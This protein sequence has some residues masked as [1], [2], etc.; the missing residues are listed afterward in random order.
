MTDKE[1]FASYIKSFNTLFSNCEDLV[2]IKD[3]EFKYQAVTEALLSKLNIG[4]INQMINKFSTDLT[5]IPEMTELLSK[6]AKQDQQVLKERKTGVY[7]NF[8][9]YPEGMEA[10]V[11]YKTPIINPETDNFVGM[12][13]EMTQLIL[14]HIAKLL[15]KTHGT[16]GLLI[17]KAQSKNPIKEYNIS[18]MHHIVLFL[19]INNYSYTEISLLISEFIKEI[20]PIQVNGILEDL[21]LMLHVRTKNQLIEKAIGLNFNSYLP[22]ALFKPSTI[23]A[24]DD[25]VSIVN[26][27]K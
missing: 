26:L 8:F 7:I 27:S 18:E 16:K 25:L 22:R 23:N 14:P 21:K 20:T 9:P 4:N 6:L 5:T 17:T 13:G 19:C 3:A 2:Y 1:Y 10:Y 15:F 11:I 12:R 24:S